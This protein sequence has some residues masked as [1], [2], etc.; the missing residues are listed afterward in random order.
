MHVE[1]YRYFQFVGYHREFP[2]WLFC[3]ISWIALLNSKTWEWPLE[4]Y[5][6]AHSECS[7]IAIPHWPTLISLAPVC[8]I[9]C[10][11]LIRVHCQE[12]GTCPSICW[13]VHSTDGLY[14]TITLYYIK[15]HYITL[16]YITLHHITSHHITS[17]HITLHYITLHHI[18]LHYIHH[19]L[20]L[21]WLFWVQW[22]Y[23]LECN[24]CQLQPSMQYLRIFVLD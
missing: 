24:L 22:H 5:S 20:S 23:P 17:H 8:L 11:Y 9:P 14:I 10:C 21:L 18:T 4:S 19:Y 3:T 2:V 16:H 6:Y 12:H 13:F 7:S 1:L 15:L